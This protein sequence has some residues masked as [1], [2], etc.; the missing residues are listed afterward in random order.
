MTSKESTQLHYNIIVAKS[1]GLSHW[2]D[3]R[4]SNKM[5]SFTGIGNLQWK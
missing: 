4:A 3:G 1:G 2:L 5:S